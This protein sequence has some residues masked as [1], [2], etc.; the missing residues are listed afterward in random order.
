MDN[1]QAYQS[2][3]KRLEAKRGFY[4]HL[5]VYVVVILLLV[6]INFVTSSGTMWFQWPMLGWGIGVVFHALGVF[7]F[8]SRFAVT[9]NMIKKEMNRGR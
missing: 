6:A 4:I 8:P 1:N 5:S 9:E 2:A 3:K 7:V